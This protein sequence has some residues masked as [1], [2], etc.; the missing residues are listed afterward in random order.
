MHHQAPIAGEILSLASDHDLRVRYSGRDQGFRADQILQA[1]IGPDTA[2][3]QDQTV[4]LTY[5]RLRS[6]VAKHNVRDDVD[7]LARQAQLLD[8]HPLQLFTVDN[9]VG[10]ATKAEVHDPLWH[11]LR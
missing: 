5:L 9:E 11:L 3:K 4:V 2:E 10:S 7:A 6:A 8:D 1:L